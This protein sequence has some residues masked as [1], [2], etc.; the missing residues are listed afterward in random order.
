MR[1]LFKTMLG[2]AAVAAGLYLAA[3]AFLYFQQPHLLYYPQA[4]RG[5]DAPALPLRAHGPRAV[6]YFGGNAE[7]ESRS[8]P[9][10][11]QAIP[12]QSL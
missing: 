9:M 7:D 5:R 3:C 2:F 1:R 10:L 4:A 12:G 8:L 6:S 11:A